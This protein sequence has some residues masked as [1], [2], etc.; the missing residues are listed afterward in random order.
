MMRARVGVDN[1]AYRVHDDH[2][3]GELVETVGERRRLEAMEIDH[4]ADEHGASY[5]RRDQLKPPGHAV[6]D[7]PLLG[8]A[9]SG[10]Q[11]TAC[12][13]LLQVGKQ[14]VIRSKDARPRAGP[15][16]HWRA[17]RRPATRQCIPATVAGL[18]Q[19]LTVL[20]CWS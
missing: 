13:A 11:C 6:V 18:G 15:S 14:A 9:H 1:A 8:M 7:R 17:P 2:A 19:V 5:V 10:E 4:L 16:S 20:T 3:R 12:C